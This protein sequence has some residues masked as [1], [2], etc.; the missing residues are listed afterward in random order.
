MRPST[1]KERGLAVE[2]SS[3][4]VREPSQDTPSVHR[5]RRLLGTLAAFVLLGAIFGVRMWLG[6]TA[7]LP[8][9][10]DSANA[11]VVAR[12]LAGGRGYTVDFVRYHVIPYSS[13]TH[14]EDTF[15]LVYPTLA[16]G[17]TRLFGEGI[18]AV[19][20][21]NILLATF[22]LPLGTYWAAS[23]CMKARWA[24]LAAVLVMCSSLVN[25]AST[26]GWNDVLSTVFVLGACATVVAEGF[27]EKP[28]RYC[29]AFGVFAGIGAMSK[30]ATA[31]MLAGVGAYAIVRAIRAR[32]LREG[33]LCW[34]V[35]SAAAV[36]SYSPFAVRNL[37]VHGTLASPVQSYLLPRS[38]AGARDARV[39]CY[40][41]PYLDEALPL[42]EVRAR[43]YMRAAV[44]NALGFVRTADAHLAQLVLVAMLVGIFAGFRWAVVLALVGGALGTWTTFVHHFESRY[45]IPVIPLGSIVLASGC[46]RLDDF[47]AS[48]GIRGRRL[49]GPALAGLV[50]ALILALQTGEWENYVTDAIRERGRSKES[51]NAVVECVQSETCPDAVIMG[52]HVELVT[53]ATGRAAVIPPALPLEGVLAVARR[54]GVSHYLALGGPRSPTV[55]DP[56]YD[57]H[58][59]GPFELVSSTEDGR[60]HLY[61]LTLSNSEG[62]TTAAPEHLEPE[63]P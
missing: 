14:P 50:I 36:L 51:W 27:E 18:L 56:L 40:T 28:V 49:F 3:S 37:A 6:S 46:G 61:R 17:A 53:F 9:T 58:A 33:M 55:L 52:H 62:A 30:A 39:V 10:P 43:D 34:L 42:P 44:K 26:Q 60:A 48:R 35:L 22:V 59:F 12:N 25:R 57:G 38:L 29:A 45:F 20:L 19:W 15:E 41:P 63:A 5:G 8:G 4:H 2:Q 24:A 21:P 7:V 16:A 1:V 31:V 23:R 32:G 13:V 54:Y 11:A 47:L